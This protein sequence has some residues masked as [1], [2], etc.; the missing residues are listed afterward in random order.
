MSEADAASE[1]AVEFDAEGLT[2]VVAQEGETGE[3]LMLAHASAEAISRTI[4][5][6]L[7][8]YYSR[9]RGELWRK[10]ETSGNVQRVEDVRI[11]CDG[12]SL[13]YRVSQ[14]GGACHT[15]HRTC[16]YR[17][18]GNVSRGASTEDGEDDGGGSRDREYS[19]DDPEGLVVETEGVADRVFDP[20]TVYGE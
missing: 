12:D 19:G 7:A 20:D 4:E 2:P 1:V 8:H 13:L 9:S 6:G 16:F 18:V 3:V 10:G 17:S 11:D 5:T 14:A 15:G